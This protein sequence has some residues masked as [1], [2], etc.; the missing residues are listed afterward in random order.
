MCDIS[1]FRGVNTPTLAYFVLPTTL[2]AGLATDTRNGPSP[3]R[4]SQLETTTDFYLHFSKILTADT[5][6]P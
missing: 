5:G 6:Q 1:H 3:A 2:N 4:T